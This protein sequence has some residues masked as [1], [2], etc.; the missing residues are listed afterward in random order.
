MNNRQQNKILPK[1]RLGNTGLLVSQL[2]FGTGTNGWQ[3]RSNQSELGIDR[4]AG[5]LRL[6][7]D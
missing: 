7:Y 4:L 2:S 1:V 3:G 6:A 5:L